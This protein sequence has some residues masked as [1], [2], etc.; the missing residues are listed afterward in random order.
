MGRLARGLPPDPA[1]QVVE[2]ARQLRRRSLARPEVGQG[3]RCW[4]SR[5]PKARRRGEGVTDPTAA[6]HGVAGWLRL[7]ATPTFAIMALL[8]AL[9]GSQ[10]DWLCSSG[11]GAPLN[12]MVT[13]YL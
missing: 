6:A 3:F 1:I 8:T 11:R 13:M 10:M 12:G 7:A 9:V 4:R 5:L 2:L